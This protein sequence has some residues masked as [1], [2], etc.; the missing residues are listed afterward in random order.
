MLEFLFRPY[1][2]GEAAAR[3]NYV[4][5]GTDRRLGGA[6]GKV[7]GRAQSALSFKSL[8]PPTR[9][10]ERYD[11]GI[12]VECATAP[13]GKPH[14]SIAIPRGDGRWATIRA[15]WRYD[16]HW[17]DERTIGYNPHPEIIG[18]YIADVIVK[19]NAERTFIEEHP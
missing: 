6:L 10:V 5:P 19:L 18:G 14:L 1:V 11:H 17:G 9:H 8:S 4:N 3:L 2:R 13:N 12:L 15:G 16:Q 7:L